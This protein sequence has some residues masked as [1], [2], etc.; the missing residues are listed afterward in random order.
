MRFGILAIS[1]LFVLLG[2]VMMFRPRQMLHLI[3]RLREDIS[4]QRIARALPGLQTP[5]LGGI[6]LV[7]LGL[8]IIVGITTG[9]IS[10]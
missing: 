9:L 1:T 5:V 4:G 6:G 7:S 10:L 8:F 2:L 3:N